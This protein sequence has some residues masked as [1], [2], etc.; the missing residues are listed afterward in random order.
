M[1]SVHDLHGGQLRV[2]R[3]LDDG[4]HRVLGLHCWHKLVPRRRNGV[5][6]LHRVPGRHF[7]ERLVLLDCGHDN[8]HRLRCRLLLEHEQ[9]GVVHGLPN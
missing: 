8:V 3:V 6:S 9:H 1:R 7:E 5:H 2:N 4:R